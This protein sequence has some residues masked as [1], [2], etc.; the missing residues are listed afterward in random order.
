MTLE[1]YYLK[2]KDS[3][4]N[5]GIRLRHSE[6]SISSF[7][8]NHIEY[9]FENTIMN[10]GKFKGT[11]YKNIPSNYL[12]WFSSNSSNMNI[13]CG[14]KEELKRRSKIKS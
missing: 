6:R 11:K 7:D 8:K 10:F 14:F 13:V 12:E 5:K 4:Y 1:A 3:D 9:D 2:R